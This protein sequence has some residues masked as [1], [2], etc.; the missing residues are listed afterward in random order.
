M[1]CIRS[2]SLYKENAH[3]KI[4]VV[5]VVWNIEPKSTKLAALEKH[6]M[7]I[8]QSKVELLILLLSFAF[9]ETLLRS[10]SVQPQYVCSQTL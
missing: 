10:C 2:Y 4:S 1:S 9:V 3:L 6:T 8:S 7:E 5:E